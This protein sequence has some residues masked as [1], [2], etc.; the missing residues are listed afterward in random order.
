MPAFDFGPDPACGD[1]LLHAVVSE[2]GGMV[3]ACDE[4]DAVYRSPD[5]V[6]SEPPAYPSRADG[7]ALWGTIHLHPGTWR[8]A[9]V[10]E[11]EEHGWAS[12]IHVRLI[13]EIRKPPE[14]LG[15]GVAIKI[16][17][18]APVEAL[19]RSM[20]PVRLVRGR[21]LAGRVVDE[22]HLTPI[23]SKTF[24]G[25]NRETEVSGMAIPVDPPGDLLF[26]GSVRRLTST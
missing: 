24:G 19:T 21:R 3:L 20:V 12:K 4:D 7:F 8:Y 6:L 26:E 9:T 22:L 11:V 13:I 10:E 15:D 25:L 1:G 14:L 5:A 18:S 2:G 17:A 23:G 16:A